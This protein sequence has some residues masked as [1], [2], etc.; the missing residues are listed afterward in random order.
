MDRAPTAPS[1]EEA[2]EVFLGDPGKESDVQRA[3]VATGADAIVALGEF[4]VVPA[5]VASI[6]AGLPAPPLSAVLASHDKRKMRELWR[7]AGILQPDFRVVFDTLKALEAA[8]EIGYPVVVKAPDLS[9]ARGVLKASS[10][11]ELTEAAREVARLAPAGFVVERLWTGMEISVEGYVGAE[12]AHVLAIA[13]KV[14]EP[15]STYSVTR[16][17]NYPADIDEDTEEE[18]RKLASQSTAALGLTNSPFHLEAIVSQ[19]GIVPLECAARGGGGHI[20][21]PIV[22]LVS[23]V[24]LVE[25]TLCLKLGEPIPSPREATAACYR[26]MFPSVANVGRIADAESARK[27]RGVVDIVMSEHSTEVAIATSGHQRVGFMVT[28]GET[29]EEAMANA[30]AAEGRVEWR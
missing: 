18:V 28:T 24:D 8:E 11:D 14:I 27:C 15:D 10:P 17:I 12:E 1:L 9:G 30:D 22:G 5:C 21:S 3:A 26:F 4:G 25:A 7:E 20:Y 23:G 16:S 6:A 2:D 29:R 19:D 13:D